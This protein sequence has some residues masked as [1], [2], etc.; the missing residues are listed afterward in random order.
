MSLY[1]DAGALAVGVGV[2]MGWRKLKPERDKVRAEGEAVAVNTL[3]DVVIE[4]RAEV[5][6][7]RLQLSKA[8]NLIEN[9]TGERLPLAPHPGLA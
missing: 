4:L 3:R 7:L 1:T 9:L 8:E 5:D 2:A 6:R